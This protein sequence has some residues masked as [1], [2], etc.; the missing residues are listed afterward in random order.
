MLRKLL[1][2]TAMTLVL[3]AALW[4]TQPAAAQSGLSPEDIQ[5]M[6]DAHNADRRR[7][8]AAEAQRLGGTVVI[9]D[10][11]WDANLA[12]FAQEWADHLIAFDPPRMFHRT[13]SPYGENLYW[14]AA[15]GRPLDLTPAVPVRSW[16]S[17]ETFY[18][19]D[20]NTCQAG[21][22]CGHYTQVVWA[23]T[24]AVGCGRA[25]RTYNGWDYI[26]WVCNYNP[27]GNFN[28]ER[29]YTV[30]PATEGVIGGT[31]TTGGVPAG[32]INLTLRRCSNGSCANAGTTTTGADGSYR[33]TNAA[34]LGDGESYGVGF[35]N[36]ENGYNESYLWYWYG[37][38]IT[39]Y[40]SGANAD[41]GSF[42]IVNVALAGPQGGATVGLPAEFSWISR[43]IPGESYSVSFYDV[44]TWSEVASSQPAEATSLTVGADLSV[45]GATLQA[46]TPY[47]WTVFV[48]NGTW[49]QG[50][51]ESYYY[52][53]VTL[54]P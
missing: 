33:F 6:V 16:V 2:V 51:G 23:N 37:P 9:P 42:D 41:G 32:G 12:A 8:A 5:A 43:G 4:P 10:L 54:Q 11:A 21:Q 18:N 53:T 46:N 7:V 3:L 29:P 24:T 48:V 19:Y 44:N 36:W 27:P 14:G 25:T 49:S 52:R 47:N 39:S 22:Q 28:G 34:S 15:S 50:Y 20:S 35:R 13:N 26:V 38:R 45:N 40:S 31:V 17:E 30:A 1:L